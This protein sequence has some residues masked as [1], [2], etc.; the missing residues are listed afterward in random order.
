MKRLALFIAAA[1]AGLALAVPANSEQSAL[2]TIRALGFSDMPIFSGETSTGYGPFWHFTKGARP[3]QGKVMV[4]GGHDVTAVPGY[5]KHGPFYN[6]VTIKKGY[7]VVVHWHGK[8]Y[9]YK[10]VSK[11]KWHPESDH[12]VVVDRGIEAIWIYSCWPRYTH[13]GRLWVEA[14]RVISN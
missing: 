7:L 12:Y 8:T 1:V 14:D 11:P 3:G 2:L 4:M 13:D 9:T 6:L 5:G 10:F